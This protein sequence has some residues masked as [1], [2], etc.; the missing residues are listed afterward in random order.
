MGTYLQVAHNI[1]NRTKYNEVKI[2]LFNFY[3]SILRS[4]RTPVDFIP[5]ADTFMKCGNHHIYKVCSSAFK[6]IHALLST[7]QMVWSDGLGTLIL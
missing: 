7:G 5:L 4:I 3:Q 6:A 2:E 1:L